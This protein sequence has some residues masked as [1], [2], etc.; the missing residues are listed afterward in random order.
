MSKTSDLTVQREST[1]TPILIKSY[2]EFW[3]PDVVDWERT[4]KLKDTRRSDSTG[5]SVNVYEERGV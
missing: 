4:R 1:N 5:P 3:N 2:G